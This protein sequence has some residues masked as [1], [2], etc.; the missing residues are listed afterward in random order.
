MVSAGCVV[1]QYARREET[2]LP[3]IVIPAYDE[4]SSIAELL[5]R[6]APLVPATEIVVV[7]N[8]CHD[9]T[10]DVARSA[11][12]WAIVLDLPQPG[13]P[14]ALDAGDATA[15]SFPRLYLDVDV[16]IS[17]EQCRAL[18]AAVDAG[19]PAA[20][21][22]PQYDV[23]GASW[24]VRSYQRFWEN[25]PANR[26]GLAGTS[27]MAVSEAARGRFDRWPD[28]MADDYFLDGLF[29]D[30]EKARIQTAMVTRPAS[31]RFADC[32]SRKARIQQGNLDTRNAGLHSG[33]AGG[34]MGG[35]KT[36]IAGNPAMLR[37]LPA[38]LAVTVAARLLAAWRRQRGTSGIRFRDARRP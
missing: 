2:A 22:T 23:A 35:I 5:S 4:E 26:R 21:A 31:A 38:H 12:P 11:A 16:A 7:C 9:K 10:A 32:V 20:G 14:A 18:F 28:T 19:L 13:K 33:H 29:A 6:L 15:K 17:A 24:V 25:L 36:V 34:G 27:A 30:S 3:S 37:D 1:A 8:G